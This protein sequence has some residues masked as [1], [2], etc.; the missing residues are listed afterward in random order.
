MLDSSMSDWEILRV[1]SGQS[2]SSFVNFNGFLG[3]FRSEARLL[4]H[5]VS[6][7][8]SM[9]RHQ[10]LLLKNP[11]GSILVHTYKGFVV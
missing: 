1:A 11:S 10:Q 8:K 7:E 6:L 5:I 4:V 3:E 9:A 2:C